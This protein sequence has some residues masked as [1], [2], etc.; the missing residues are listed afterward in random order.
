M[1]LEKFDVKY[2]PFKSLDN[3]MRKLFDFWRSDSK[4]FITDDVLYNHLFLAYSAIKIVKQT[5][6]LGSADRPESS[7]IAITKSLEARYYYDNELNKIGY[8]S[9]K[10][11]QFKK[12]R[13][14]VDT[15]RIFHVGNC[16]WQ[17]YVAFYHLIK[18]TTG[19]QID[20]MYFEH[21]DH[22]FVVI[23]RKKNSCIHDYLTWG[24]NAVVC[25]PWGSRYFPVREMKF[26][27]NDIFDE[28]KFPLIIDYVSKKDKL[29]KPLTTDVYYSNEVQ[30]NEIELSTIHNIKETDNQKLFGQ[31]C[32]FLSIK[33]RCTDK[34]TFMTNCFMG[35]ISG[36]TRF[37]HARPLLSNLFSS[38]NAYHKHQNHPDVNPWKVEH[39]WFS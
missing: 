13:V 1:I 20:I 15:A 29:A 6:F 7:S 21:L 37:P 35:V 25:D 2:A 39:S 24:K 23:G 33:N 10:M 16:N 18:H 36:H 22:V 31:Y 4:R 32:V 30:S 26:Q 12:V 38:R 19:T 17:A 3:D 5:V 9:S 11:Y 28:A 8:F 14:A 27:M 34:P